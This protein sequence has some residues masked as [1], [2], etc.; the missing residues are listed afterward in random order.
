MAM[1]MAMAVYM[2][3]LLYVA[4]SIYAIRQAERQ[5]GRQSRQEYS[6]G[7]C[8]LIRYIRGMVMLSRHIYV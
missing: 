7:T 4:R 8:C 2:M 5:A 1:A 6:T 3:F